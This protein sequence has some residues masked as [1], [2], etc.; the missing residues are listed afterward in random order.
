M[1][2]ESLWVSYQRDLTRSRLKKQRRAMLGRAFFMAFTI[3]CLSY[4]IGHSIA[5]GYR[6]ADR[7]AMGYGADCPQ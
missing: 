4:F 6:I 5:Y 2:K 3:A 7:K 1:K